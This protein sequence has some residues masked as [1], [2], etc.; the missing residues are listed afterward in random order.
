[1]RTAYAAQAVPP[2]TTVPTSPAPVPAAPPPAAATPAS[3]DIRVG[4]NGYIYGIDGMLDQIAGACMRQAKTEL[5][6]VIQQDYKMQATVGRAAGAAMARPL[7]VIAGIAA[8][9]VGY[10]IYQDRRRR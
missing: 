8:V 10:K 9:Y 5:L 7:W 6:P 1:M 4:A 2:A 3:S